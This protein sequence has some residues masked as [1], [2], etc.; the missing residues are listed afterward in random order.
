MNESKFWVKEPAI[1]LQDMVFFPTSN[2]SQDEKLNSLTRLAIIIAIVMYS[3]NYDQW[4]VFLLVSLLSIIILQSCSSNIVTDTP[5]EREREDFT[6]V[7]THVGDDFHTTVVA[8]LFA[9]EH[10]VPPPAYDHY[11]SVD[12][13]P[14]MFSEPVRPQSHPYGQYLTRTNLLP[15]DEYTVQLNPNG[16]AKTTREYVNSTFTKH[17]LA[18]QE[19]MMRMHYKKLNRRFR[20]NKNDTY[21]P[22]HGY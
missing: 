9:E 15:G 12:F 21:S 13:T 8:P 17:R 11:T 5:L 4:L 3:M 10:R 16:G 14:S 22:F 20:S 2:M 18:H 1:L 7:P 6:I 19:N